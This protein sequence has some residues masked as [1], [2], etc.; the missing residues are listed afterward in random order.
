[1]DNPSNTSLSSFP[2]PSSASI[3]N[4]PT[5]LSYQGRRYAFVDHA[6]NR[7]R[8][9]KQ[10]GIWEFGHE[11]RDLN[12]SARRIWRCSLC[13]PNSIFSLSGNTTAPSVSHLR[14]KHRKL[15][16]QE[17]ATS[18]Q[19]DQ[20]IVRSLVHGVNISRF[21]YH[22]LRWIVQRHISFTEVEDEDFQAILV[23]LNSTIKPYLVSRNTIRNWTENEFIEARQQIITEVL[24]KAISRIHV[25]F[26][27]WTSPNG[28]AICGIVAHFVGHQYSNQNVLLAL[29]R[30]TGPHGGEDIAE[31]IIPTLQEYKIVDKLGVFVTDNVES[32]DTAIRA[33]LN[34]VRPEL[35]LKARRSRCL[36]HIIN[37]VAKAFLFGTSVDA[38]E[39]ITDVIDEDVVS[40]DS[41]TMKRAQK[42]WRTQG[43]IGK[44]HNL[45]V[46][47][48]SSPQRRETFKRKVVGDDAVDNL[49]PILDNSTRWNSTYKALERAILLRD[50]IFLFCREYRIDIQ[51]D[52]LS[53]EDWNRLREVYKGL[54][55]FY[56]AT[57][58]V[59]GKAGG[60]H[61]GAI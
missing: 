49:M 54:K 5:E 58:R 25:S 8:G 44:L 21:R 29:K 57:L 19:E 32:N 39:A 52:Y 61:H 31:V 23:E 9:S 28:Y 50:R 46:F 55:P 10:S 20:E 43:A 14:K 22:L 59:E 17:E 13:L 27:L 2:L 34:Q 37:L 12:D 48:R 30:L 1:M 40:I 60:G 56:Q 35:Q 16:Q 24:R 26:D 7:R 11:Y 53:E 3:S 38:F 15:L 51:A 36:G 41:E 4:P 33:I 45:V 42:A 47:I 6:A 18:E